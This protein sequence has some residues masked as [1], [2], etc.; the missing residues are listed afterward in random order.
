MQIIA[1]RAPRGEHG[2]LSLVVGRQICQEGGAASLRTTPALA[3]GRALPGRPTRRRRRGSGDVFFFRRWV[4]SRPRPGPLQAASGNGDGCVLAGRP[5]VQP[6]CSD[7]PPS[8]AS[9]SSNLPDQ[10]SAKATARRLRAAAAS[11]PQRR[12]PSGPR[13]RW[14][15]SRAARR[16][17]RRPKGVPHVPDGCR[18]CSSHTRL[19]CSCRDRRH[20]TGGGR[21]V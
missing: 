19:V 2:S 20:V 5:W 7:L 16:G 21:G 17:G 13:G 12:H 10:R 15:W 14:S 18:P 1:G 3:T 11:S 8:S 4:R 9:L 6:S